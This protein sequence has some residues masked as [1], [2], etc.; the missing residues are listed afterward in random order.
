MS[1]SIKYKGNEIA[2]MT[3]SGT[4]TLNTAGKYCDGNITVQNT[5]GGAGLPFEAIKTVS[6]DDG[7]ITFT[8]TKQYNILLVKVKN[9]M[10]V[11]AA[12]IDDDLGTATGLQEFEPSIG[13]FEIQQAVISVTAVKT[14]GVTTYTYTWKVSDTS[15]GA[16]Y[17]N[18]YELYGHAR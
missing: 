9:A 12:I 1:V 15:R 2:A 3:A 7:I 8:S 13:E 18:T 4:K 10:G 17:A 11:L 5:E 14:N 16:Y 6:I